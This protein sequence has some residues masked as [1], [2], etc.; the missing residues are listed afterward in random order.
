MRNHAENPC[1][2]STGVLCRRDILHG[3]GSQGTKAGLLTEAR[4]APG[5]S[6]QRSG[7]FM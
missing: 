2:S 7:T 5:N 3:A 1:F 4:P 6:G